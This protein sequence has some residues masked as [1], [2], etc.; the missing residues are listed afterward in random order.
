MIASNLHS[1]SLVTFV[2]KGS[3]PPP[4][5]GVLFRKR[6]LD[7]KPASESSTDCPKGGEKITNDILLKISLQ[8]ENASFRNGF[9]VV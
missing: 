4:K 3:I 6:N 5:L 9:D 2:G 7:M 8:S 1:Y